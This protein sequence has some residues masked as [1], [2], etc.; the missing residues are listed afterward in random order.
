MSNVKKLMSIKLTT[1]DALVTISVATACGLAFI[2]I[3]G[4]TN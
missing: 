4:A 2:F 1:L 3:I